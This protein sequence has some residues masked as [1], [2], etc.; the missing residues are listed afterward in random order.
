MIQ[1]KQRKPDWLKIKAVGGDKFKEINRL[2]TKYGVQTFC[3]A[4]NCPNRSECFYRGT[5]TF[6]ILG[7]KCTRNC[8]F[9]VI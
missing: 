8:G 6:L 4:A 2:I 3:Q 9:C 5:S 7:S 1:K